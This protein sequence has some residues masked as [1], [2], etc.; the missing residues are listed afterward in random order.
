MTTDEVN[1]EKTKLDAASFDDKSL[2]PDNADL[3]DPLKEIRRCARELW[4]K[5][6]CPSVG[7]VRH[8]WSLAEEQLT[9]GIPFTLNLS[10]AAPIE[11][12]S[13]AVVEA[14]NEGSS[15]TDS[16]LRLL[17]KKV[18]PPP[19]NYHEAICLAR[20]L[21]TST[22]S[23]AAAI[24]FGP[25]GT[26]EIAEVLSGILVKFDEEVSERTPVATFMEHLEWEK[27]LKKLFCE[28]VALT[29]L[30]RTTT[31][32]LIDAFEKEPS[33]T[34]IV[35]RVQTTTKCRGCEECED[36]EIR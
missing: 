3:I 15:C 24:A 27:R 8:Y 20:I 14:A 16:P 36:R 22:L 11:G 19:L 26:R 18:L 23:T 5:D 7:S 31:A 25:I 34:A 10:C 2:L 28:D 1:S 12:E 17:I 33:V 9:T 29:N 30:D 4:Q 32:R 35:P 6:G 13:D 21:H